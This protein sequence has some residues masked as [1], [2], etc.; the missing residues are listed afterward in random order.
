MRSAKG[1]PGVAPA[2]AVQTC[3]Q[4]DGDRTSVTGVSP[5]PPQHRRHPA[6]TL[7]TPP[8]TPEGAF[9]VAETNWTL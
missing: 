8:E 9:V 6:G 2:E 3:G 5:P 1:Y 4:W 7:V